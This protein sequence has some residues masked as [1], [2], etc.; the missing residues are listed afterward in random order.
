METKTPSRISLPQATAAAAHLESVGVPEDRMIGRM[1]ALLL[2]VALAGCTVLSP[3]ARVQHADRLA[4]ASGWLQTRLHTDAFTLAAYVPGSAGASDTLTIYIEGDGLAW[5]SRSQVSLDPTPMHP[6]GLEL[7]LRHPAGAAAYLARPCQ[8]LDA[9]DARNCSPVYWTDRR[10]APEMVTAANQAVEQLKQRFNAR[11]LALVG[12]SGG[13]AIASLVAAR[14]DDI[15]L[16]LTVAGNLDHRA[17]T[18]HHHASPLK[19]SLNPADEWRALEKLPQLHFVGGK[20]P[21]ITPEIVQ[22]YLAH[23]PQKHRSKLQVVEDFDH[24]CCWTQSWNALAGPAFRSL[25]AA[26]GIGHETLTK[27]QGN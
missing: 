8:Y 9:A 25:P 2:C 14:R 16:L 13:A 6:V 21:V 11:H 5:I 23:F 26:P 15:S 24:A 27:M 22:S 10:F 7:A 19:G 20:D 18:K 3:Q 1:P 4:A 17:W 12:Y